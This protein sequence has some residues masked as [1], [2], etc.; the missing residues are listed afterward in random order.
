MSGIPAESSLVG[1]SVDKPIGTDTATGNSNSNPPKQY[2]EKHFKGEST[3]SLFT[4]PV[5]S[6]R[7]ISPAPISF[8]GAATRIHGFIPFEDP[9]NFVEAKRDL[10][11]PESPPYIPRTPDYISPSTP[12]PS[13]RLRQTNPYRDLRRSKYSR[14]RSDT[15]HNTTPR[16]N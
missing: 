13:P 8:V 2:Y 16:S 15:G 11:F 10:P 5:Q 7:Q 6:P 12:L 1:V 4:L 14:G 3:L 9:V